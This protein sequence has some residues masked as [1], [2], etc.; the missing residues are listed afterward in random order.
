MPLASLA[1]RA[2]GGFFLAALAAAPVLA[3]D[4]FDLSPEQAGRIHAKPVPAAIE[5]LPKD[6]R[7][8]KPGHFTVA[9]TPGG[10]P[11]GT[12]ATDA[13]TVVGADPD[14]ASLIAEALGLQLDLVPVAWADW[15]LGLASGNTTP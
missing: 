7:F 1:R 11:L 3:A 6:A 2:I 10:P 12:Y 15:P 14:Y 9:I 5:A 4:G 13:A 8:V